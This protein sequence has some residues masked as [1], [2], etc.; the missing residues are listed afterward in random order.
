MVTLAEA[1]LF[2]CSAAPMSMPIC[3]PD[4]KGTHLLRGVGIAGG[5]QSQAQGIEFVQQRIEMS[6]SNKRIIV[7]IVFFRFCN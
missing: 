3:F 6:Q 7:L 2:S 4:T 1:S 5:A